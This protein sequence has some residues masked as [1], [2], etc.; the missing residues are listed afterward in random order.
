MRIGLSA[1]LCMAMLM[2]C[3]YQL[4]GRGDL[5]G[6]IQTIAVQ[7]LENRSS[8]TGAEITFTNAL[9]NELN[10]RRRGS[11]V[12]TGRADATL[13]GTIE[14]ISWDTVSRSGA[15]T[16]TERRVYASLSLTLTDHAGN[17]LWRR[18]GLAAE[19]AYG[20]VDGDKTATENNRRLAINLL[21]E[22]MAEY[23]YR[24]L[25]DNF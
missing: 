18:S 17:V 23:V 1:L 25:T 8:Q 5:P 15:N 12:Q 11:V 14:S 7:V 24:R 20:V 6:G 4:A 19:Q 21:S 9:I 16:A 13:N 2:G 22:Q 10:R 3:G